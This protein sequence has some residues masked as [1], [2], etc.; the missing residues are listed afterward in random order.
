MIS[1]M[2]DTQP[3]NT[4]QQNLKSSYEKIPTAVFTGS[5]PENVINMKY[6]NVII[7]ICLK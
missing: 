1:Q 5:P 7:N 4:Q 6:M 2:K 3:E